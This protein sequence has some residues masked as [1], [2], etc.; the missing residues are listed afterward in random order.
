MK[1]FLLLSFN[2]LFFSISPNAQVSYTFMPVSGTYAPITGGTIASLATPSIQYD[3]SDEGYAN[4]ISIGF[5]FSYNGVSYENLNV[6]VN[7]F[8]TLGEGFVDDDSEN[9]YF[10][11]LSAGAISQL[12]GRPIIAPLWDDLAVETDN[13][14]TYALTGV[15]PNKVFTIQ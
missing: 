2:W 15:T 11:S 13:N 12:S 9:Y 8:I 3:V 14:V 6:N 4:E 7:G 1:K 10:N 5:T